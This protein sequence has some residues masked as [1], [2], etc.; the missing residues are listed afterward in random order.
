M[1][2]RNTEN[3]SRVRKWKTKKVAAAV[4]A[5]L[6]TLAAAGAGAGPLRGSC[7]VSIGQLS[8][9]DA[10]WRYLIR[11]FGRVPLIGSR[12]GYGFS[13]DVTAC[14]RVCVCVC[15][16]VCLSVCL[17]VTRQ[18]T[19]PRSRNLK[20]SASIRQSPQASIRFFISDDWI[21]CGFVAVIIAM[22]GA[23]NRL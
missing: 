8:I 4:V 10:C 17:C 21:F 7:Q 16:C 6:A 13:A 20:A 3:W 11:D 12:V 18:L 22:N 2:T 5:T 9:I 15:V 19:K 1:N 23:F 14:L